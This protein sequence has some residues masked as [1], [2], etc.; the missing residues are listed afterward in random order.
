MKDTI[1]SMY[2]SHNSAIALSIDGVIQPIIEVERFCNAKNAATSQY[3]VVNNPHIV[4]QSIMNWIKKTY[5]IEEFDVCLHQNTEVIYDEI[6]YI[7]HS[8][9][10]AKTK[11]SQKHHESHAAGAFYQ[12]PYKEA[13]IFS[14]DGGGNDGKFN[15][16]MAER[17]SG[18]TLLTSV[19]NPI[20]GSPHIYYDLGFPYMI[21]GHYL[22]DIRYE[23]IGDGNLVY[24]GKIMGLVSYGNIN[25]EWLPHFINFYKQDPQGHNYIELLNTLGNEIG[26]T[27]DQNDRLDGQLAY[28]IA[29]TSQKAFEE[30]FLEV[31]RPYM[32]MYPN[33]PICMAGGCAL[34]IILNTKLVNEFNKSVFVGPNPSDCGI[35]IGSLL[36]YLKPSDP[37]DLTY[38]GIPI[39]DI[40]LLSD[41]AQSLPVREL[42][43]EQVFN[44]YFKI[45]SDILLNDIVEGS[46]VGV[47]R[48]NSEHGPRALGN[49]L[50]IENGID[51][52]H[53]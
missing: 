45:H 52:L 33:L 39:L 26:V 32:E 14:F 2:G 50:K 49:K 21:F 25:Y 34:N 28:D 11:I 44:P 1:I 6:T 51:H 3:K 20:K 36:N 16:Y 37:I 42:T 23:S 43:T 18:V 13:L 12:S 38:M 15:I 22:K 8:Y 9:I 30:C 29:A 4:V 7:M 19:L 24:S 27:F 5:N 53:R 47:M 48:G 17:S 40:D 35:A 46:I 31:A 10:N 41:Y